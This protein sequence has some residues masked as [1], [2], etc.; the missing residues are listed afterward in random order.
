M[1]TRFERAKANLDM[2]KKN[3]E[4][5]LQAMAEL[6]VQLSTVKKDFEDMEIAFEEQAYGLDEDNEPMPT[7]VKI[8]MWVVIAILLGVIVFVVIMKA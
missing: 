2:A 5:I 1:E 7:Y 4:T 3:V 8:A 6:S